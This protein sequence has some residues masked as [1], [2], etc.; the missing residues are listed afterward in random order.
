MTNT[1]R[2]NV[3]KGVFSGMFAETPKNATYRTITL[4]VFVVERNGVYG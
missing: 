2:V 1:F 4:K 3:K